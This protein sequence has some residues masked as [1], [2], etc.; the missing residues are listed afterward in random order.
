MRNTIQSN[1]HQE[2][3]LKIRNKKKKVI[4]TQ[5]TEHVQQQKNEARGNVVSG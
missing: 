3:N 1:K 4:S 5:T 2:K